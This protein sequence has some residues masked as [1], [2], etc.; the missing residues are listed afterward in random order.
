M[1]VLIAPIAVPSVARIGE[2]DISE[3]ITRSSCTGRQAALMR[4][5]TVQPLAR[6][7][8]PRT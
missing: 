3:A 7:K 4:E 5:R 6:N 1:P 2:P 8:L